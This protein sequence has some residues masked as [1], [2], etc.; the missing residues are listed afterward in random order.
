[1]ANKDYLN[2]RLTQLKNEVPALK[3]K[4]SKI[5]N[6]LND[7]D[8]ELDTF[9]SKLDTLGSYVDSFALSTQRAHDRQVAKLQKQ[10]AKL[11]ARLLKGGFVETDTVNPVAIEKAKTIAIFD[12]ILQAIT[13]WSDSG[14][15]AADVEAISQAVIFPTIYER[16]SAG[17]DP[18][19]LLSEVPDSARLVVQRAREYVKWVRSECETTLFEPAAWEKYAP[20]IQ[21]WWVNDGL[22]LLYGEA[23][24][25]WEE[26]TPYSLEQIETW[27]NNPADRV[28]A[29]PKVY[30]AIDNFTKHRPEVMK[31]D[32][33]REFLMYT[34]TTRLP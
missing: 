22:P 4:V 27:R 32:G 17:R 30:D 8:N 7:L 3:R 15:Q 19:Y 18:A 24:P 2:Y 16:V 25:E 12:I 26:D 11:E 23:D 20:T 14:D 6:A 33:F 10:I 21:E 1:M 29:F 9:V 34:T 28:V 13:S 31:E 5:E